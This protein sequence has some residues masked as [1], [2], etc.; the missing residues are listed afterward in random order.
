MFAQRLGNMMAVTSKQ[1]ETDE[2]GK[3]LTSQPNEGDDL[4]PSSH[5]TQTPDLIQYPA[6]YAVAAEEHHHHILVLPRVVEVGAVG[7]IPLAVEKGA[8]GS[9]PLVVEVP[10]SH[11]TQTPDLIQYPAAFKKEKKAFLAL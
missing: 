5:A 4:V 7:S 9:L 6:A 1:E 3:V 11:A 10:S 2:S 8:A